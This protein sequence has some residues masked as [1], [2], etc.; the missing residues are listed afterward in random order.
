MPEVPITVVSAA[1]I[2]AA[3]DQPLS[4]VRS[5]LE[6]TQRPQVVRHNG[7]PFYLPSASHAL[8]AELQAGCA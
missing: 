4:A 7:E 1:D 8:I 2:A 5:W 3:T 6:R